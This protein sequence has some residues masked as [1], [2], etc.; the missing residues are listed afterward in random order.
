[1]WRFA[2]LLVVGVHKSAGYEEQAA[3]LLA[4]PIGDD[5]EDLLSFTRTSIFGPPTRP[6]THTLL[7]DCSK[8]VSGAD[9]PKVLG[10]LLNARS[11]VQ[12]QNPPVWISAC[13]ANSQLGISREARQTARQM[14]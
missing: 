1:V 8:K 2:A 11:L 6:T 9:M 3:G 13:S 12:R 5:P 4:R 10:D 14:G 7:A